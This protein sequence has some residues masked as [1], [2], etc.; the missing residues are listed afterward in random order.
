MVRQLLV[1]VSLLFALPLPAQDAAPEGPSPGLRREIRVPLEDGRLHAPKLVRELLDAYQIDGSDI[2]LPDVSLDLRGARGFALLHGVR[3][4]LMQTVSFR[5]DAQRDELV[6]TIDRE[7]TREVRRELRGKIAKWVGLLAGED[8]AVQRCK[9]DLPAPLDRERPL[10]VLVHGVEGSARALEELRVHLAAAPR[11]VQV[12][13]FAWPNDGAAERVAAE[14][15]ESLRALAPQPIDLVAHSMG[16]LIAR[17]VVED[18]ELDPGNVRTLVLIGTPNQGT[19]LAGLRIALEIADVLRQANGTEDFARALL[20]S[21]ADHWRDGIGEAGGDLLPGSVFLTRLDAH[22]RNSRVRYH[23]VLGTRSLLSAEQVADVRDQVRAALA[24]G[25]LGNAVRPR[26]ERWLD[27]LD[28]L[29]DGKG[30]GVVSVARGELAGVETLRVP[31]DH[32]GL[33]HRD[34]VLSHVAE[35]EEHPVFAAVAEWIR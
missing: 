34:G 22:P 19:R 31:L 2:P 17:A 10:C 13:T 35:G 15:S 1:L 27:D 5:R 18:P 12:A 11:D 20:A 32:D 25:E 14:L 33:I 28:E 6:V 26:V 24:D 8:V 4:V 21:V 9:L 7:R 23:V 29:I 3:R 16:G 30:D